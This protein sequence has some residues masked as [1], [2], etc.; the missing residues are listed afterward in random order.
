[1]S[2]K[3]HHY[4]L[5]KEILLEISGPSIV[6]YPGVPSRM[7]AANNTKLGD[8]PSKYQ[9]RCPSLL[10]LLRGTDWKVTGGSKVARPRVAMLQHGIQKSYTGCQR[11]VHH[12]PALQAL[13]GG[14]H[15]ISH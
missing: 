4:L 12:S 14:G 13:G 6:Q 15:V 2:E 10:E 8:D 1:M 11:P 3:N 5:L 9:Q 7:I